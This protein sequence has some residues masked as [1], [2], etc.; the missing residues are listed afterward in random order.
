[1]TN[2]RKITR[3][4]LACFTAFAAISILAV[5]IYF[6]ADYETNAI[7]K[8]NIGNFTIVFLFLM[9]SVFS[10]ISVLLFNNYFK[11]NTNIQN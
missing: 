1:M 7:L 3:L 6:Y 5:I 10:G 8:S 4:I 2:I 11:K 9:L